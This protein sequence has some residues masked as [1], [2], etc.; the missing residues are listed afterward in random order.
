MYKE[1]HQKIRESPEPKLTEKADL[2]KWKE[3]S[4]KYHPKKLSKEQRIER[5]KAKKEAFL[6]GRE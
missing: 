3:A 5:I 6:A 2:A 1:A 4:R